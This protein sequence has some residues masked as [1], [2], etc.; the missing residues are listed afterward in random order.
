MQRQ[1]LAWAFLKVK[2]F[3]C[4]R[5]EHSKQ[6]NPTSKVAVKQGMFA[7]IHNQKQSLCHTGYKEYYYLEINQ[8]NYIIVNL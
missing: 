6:A 1:S 5:K 8:D 7:Y 2:H 3:Y 4:P